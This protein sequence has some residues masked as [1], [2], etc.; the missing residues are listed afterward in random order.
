[1]PGIAGK[2]AEKFYAACRKVPSVAP[3][4]QVTTVVPMGTIGSPVPE[5][6]CEGL[7]AYNSTELSNMAYR[8]R[9][10]SGFGIFGD[11]NVAVARGV[12]LERPED[13]RSR[14]RF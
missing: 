9:I 12:G 1:M 4:S 10:D 5:Y 3:K 2:M 14:Y 7:I 8:A 13:R 11:R 6:S